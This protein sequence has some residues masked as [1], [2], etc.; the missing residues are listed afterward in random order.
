MSLHDQDTMSEG[1]NQF[2]YQYDYDSEHDH[3]TVFSRSSRSTTRKKN[4]NA[5]HTVSFPNVYTVTKFVNGKRT[6]IKL[7]ETKERVNA[8]IINAV[9]GIPY[10]DEREEPNRKYVVGSRQEDDLFKVKMLAGLGNHTAL[11]FYESPD[12]YERHQMETLDE[13]IKK[14]WLE[15]NQAYRVQYARESSRK[16]QATCTI[17]H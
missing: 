4:Y 10:F 14:K 5:P 12:Q 6:K 17:I 11:L 3:D 2:G 1:D 15:K 7:Y 16:N 13:D 9:T 8:R